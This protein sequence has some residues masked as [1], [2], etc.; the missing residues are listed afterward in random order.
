VE[1]CV[2]DENEEEFIQ[3]STEYNLCNEK[4]REETFSLLHILLLSE[5]PKNSEMADSIT[6]RNVLSTD[7]VELNRQAIDIDNHHSVGQS[8]EKDMDKNVSE[9]NPVREVMKLTNDIVVQNKHT[10]SFIV[11]ENHVVEA[12]D[13]QVFDVGNHH[14][15]G[16]GIGQG[17]A[18]NKNE[19][20]VLDE[21]T[22]LT[23]DADTGSVVVN[24][25][26]VVE[27]STNHG[28]LRADDGENAP[29]QIPE[30]PHSATDGERRQCTV[31]GKWFVKSYLKTHMGIHSGNRHQCT[32]CGKWL[33]KYYLKT[34]VLIHSGKKPYSCSFCD[35][36]FRLK[37]MLKM[38]ELGHKGELPP[39]DLCGGRFVNLNTHVRNVHSGANYKYTCSVCK[40]GFRIQAKLKRHMS[41]HS[42]ERP[43]TCQDCGGSYRDLEY[44]KKHMAIHT[45]EK[46]HACVVCGKKFLH[47]GAMNIHMRTHTGEKPYRCETCGKT[48]RTSALISTHRKMHTLE[49]PYICTTC[50]KGFGQSVSL[51]RH[52]LIHS[53]VQPYECSECGL[54]FNQSSSMQRHVVTHTGEKPYSCTDCGQRFTQSGGLASH[55]RRH[56]SAK[57]TQT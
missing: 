20:N 9:K 28:S 2:K 12:S 24:K 38:H 25:H 11:K 52:E 35:M 6:V 23:N 10:D 41:S 54:W 53:G 48:F 27:A 40:K 42:E 34:H 43:Y 55:R 26:H 56:C 15:A 17:I 45:K 19:K 30:M 14:S 3:F 51:R 50:G 13:R 49:K 18:S 1:N 32:V 29:C 7:N 31:C 47:S 57:N 36:K 8:I 46:N 21:V 37:E 44:L 39:C 33:A 22:E 5:P 16:G 4:Y